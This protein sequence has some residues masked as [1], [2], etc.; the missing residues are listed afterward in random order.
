MKKRQNAEIRKPEIL[1][2]FYQVLLE[3]GLE[4]ASIGK[5]AKRMD[6]HPSLIIHY[7]QNR[8]N[9]TAGL[10]DYIIRGGAKVFEHLSEKTGPQKSLRDLV[11]IFFS[12]EWARMS[13]IGADF[14]V[15]SLTSRNPQVDA[16]IRN[17]YA[18]LKKLIIS[19]I[20]KVADAGSI[21]C[22]DHGRAADI[23][24]TM[25]E[26]YRHFRQFHIEDADTEDFRNDMIE[27]VMAALTT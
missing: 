9:L 23:I 5:V 26:G 18:L 16:K 17:M 1:Y 21:T 8:E 13:D 27:A 12:E 14:A 22:G 6:I 19:E 24:I 15:L 3:E 10:V 2:H 20:G 25:Y 4:G 7:F 11:W